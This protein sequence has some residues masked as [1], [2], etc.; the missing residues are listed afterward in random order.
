MFVDSG[1]IVSSVTTEIIF[2]NDK[3][4]RDF[5]V[6][7]NSLAFTAVTAV[8]VTLNNTHCRL[9]RFRSLRPK[10][11]AT[12]QPSF[13]LQRPK[14]LRNIDLN[15]DCFVMSLSTS[16][17]NINR[18]GISFTAISQP[19]LP[20]WLLNLPGVTRLVDRLGVIEFRRRLIHMSPSL[21]PVGLPFIPHSAVWNPILIWTAVLCVAVG[22][23]LA[24]SLG[25][26]MTRPGE[27]SWT[28]A[29]LGYAVPIVGGLVF[30]PGR[31][32]LG[33]M[34][35]QIIALGDGSA[36]LG[37]ILLGGRHL[38]WNPQKTVSGLFCFI[39]VGSIAATYNYW[40]E[41]HPAV[42]VGVAFLI[43]G[44]AAVFAALIESL[45]LRSNDNFR[46]GTAALLAGAVLSSIVH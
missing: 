1:R 31:A 11:V 9:A 16:H 4:A 3:S 8:G 32:E 22:L 33:L 45:P 44:G 30:F 6:K 40:G 24:L 25:P 23:C 18:P 43:C 28:V 17:D 26:R 14:R 19:P 2:P 27:S 12:Q 5:H 46:V 13:L 7:K 21:I 29:V 20:S 10:Q 34:T 41:A 35:L 42:S 38:P 37:G 36:T 39:A 15:G